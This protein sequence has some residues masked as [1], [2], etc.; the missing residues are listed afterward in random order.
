MADLGTQFTGCIKATTTD[1]GTNYSC[2]ECDSG[3]YLDSSPAS[4]S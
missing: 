3:Y 2:S 1:S 4:S